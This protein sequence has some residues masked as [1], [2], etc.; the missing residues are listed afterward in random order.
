MR[1]D[2]GTGSRQALAAIRMVAAAM[3]VI[4]GGYRIADFSRV[5]GFGEFLESRGLPAGVACAM[6]ITIWEILAGMARAVGPLPRWIAPLFALE[7]AAGIVLV[8]RGEGWFVVGG[9]RNGMEYS[10]LLI[11]VMLAVGW[12]DRK[13]NRPPAAPQERL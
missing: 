12:Q 11:A 8:H 9:G 6:L 7:L 10:V 1:K 13:C 4:H 2:D 3:M 5:A